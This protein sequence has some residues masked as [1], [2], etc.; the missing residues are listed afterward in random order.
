MNPFFPSASSWEKKKE[1]KTSERLNIYPE[2]LRLPKDSG[3]GLRL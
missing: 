3:V 1:E 2:D